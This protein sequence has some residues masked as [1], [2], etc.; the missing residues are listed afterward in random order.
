MYSNDEQKPGWCLVA[1]TGPSLMREDLDALR[2]HVDYAIAVNC[3]VFFAPWANEIF[4]A[5]SVWYRYYGP[6]IAWFK[7]NRVSRTHRAPNVVPWRGH[8]WARTGGNS[9]HMAIQRGVDLGYKQIA[10]IGFDQ[11]KTGGRAHCHIDHPRQATDGKRTNMA[12]ANGVAAWPRLMARTAGDL[13]ER[14]VTV[15]NLSRETA[16]RC[17]PRMTVERFLEDLCH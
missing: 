13:L 3:A 1:A 15:I 5:D 12:N 7:G 17:F 16:L 8:G 4:A 11:Q 9:G 10:L 14:G 2:P 6:K